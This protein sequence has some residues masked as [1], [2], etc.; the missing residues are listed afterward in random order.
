MFNELSQLVGGV[1]PSIK[2]GLNLI[3]QRNTGH[4]AK[5]NAN[6]LHYTTKILQK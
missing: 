3:N 4:V 6:D 5:I 1:Y 2:E